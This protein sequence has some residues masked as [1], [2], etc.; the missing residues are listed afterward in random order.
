M[1][2]LLERMAFINFEYMLMKIIILGLKNLLIFPL[3]KYFP[4]LV[5]VLDKIRLLNFRPIF[6]LN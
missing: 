6:S 4:P 3:E 2:I 5:E 1:N